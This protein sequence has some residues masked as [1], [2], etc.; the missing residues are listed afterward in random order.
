MSKEFMFAF[1]AVVVAA[2]SALIGIIPL[3]LLLGVPAGLLL[4]KEMITQY[5]K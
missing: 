4:I 5:R 2:V 3:A 1:V